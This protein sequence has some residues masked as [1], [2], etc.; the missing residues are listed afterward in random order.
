MGQLDAFAER[1]INDRVITDHV[2]AAQRVHADFRV[3]TCAHNSFTAMAD[4]FLDAAVKDGL[5]VKDISVGAL[6]Q[7]QTYR[8]PGNVRELENLMKRLIAMEIDD[9]IGAASVAA[10]LAGSSSHIGHNR[11][12][13]MPSSD[14]ILDFMEHHFSSYVSS[15]GDKLPPNGLYDRVLNEV[16][17]PLLRAVLSATRGNQLKAADVLGINRN[18]LRVKIKQHQIKSLR[19]FS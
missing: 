3:G 10:E 11:D 1:G 6:E 9:T 17:P 7:L 12:A 15:F 14:T 8:W 19:G 13:A 18:T 5:P 2:A 4:H 16:E